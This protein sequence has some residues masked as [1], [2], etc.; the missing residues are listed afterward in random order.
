VASSINGS[1]AVVAGNT[2]TALSGN[3]NYTSSSNTTFSGDIFG[4]ASSITLDSPAGT[5]L[6]LS[7]SNQYGGGTCVHGGTLKTSNSAALAAG[8]LTMTGGT[9][10]IDG[11]PA[12]E[13][14]SLTGSG[15]IIETSA[16]GLCTLLVSPRSGSTTAFSGAITDGNGQLALL[17]PSTAT[18]CLILSG[19]DTYT[20]GTTVLGGTLCLENASLAG[21]SLTV[22]NC[23]GLALSAAATPSAEIGTITAVPEPGTLLLLLAAIWSAAIY[24]CFF[25][26]EFALIRSCREPPQ[27]ETTSLG[28]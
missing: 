4:A 14:A 10:D 12:L 28:R 27:G 3:L 15:G 9:L 19:S 17:L 7:G 26:R 21:T 16:S 1:S 22:G 2:T 5:V 23:A 13:I 11:S 20:G 24:R 25:V 18:G 6:T 8:N